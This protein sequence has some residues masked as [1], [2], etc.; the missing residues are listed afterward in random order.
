MYNNSFRI[1][2]FDGVHNPGA[3]NKTCNIPQEVGYGICTN[4]PN[5]SIHNGLGYASDTYIKKHKLQCV[6]K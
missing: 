1:N 2:V 3:E 5:C 4:Y 6:S